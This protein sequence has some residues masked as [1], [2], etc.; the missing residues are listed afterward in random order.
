MWGRASG[1]LC[2]ATARVHS[3]EGPKESRPVRFKNCT[4][5]RSRSAHVA[6][7]LLQEGAIRQLL[8]VEVDREWRRDEMRRRGDSAL[9]CTSLRHEAARR[10]AR[11]GAADGLRLK[12]ARRL[13]ARGDKAIAQGDYD[14]A[15]GLYEQSAQARPRRAMLS[16]TWGRTLQSGSLSRGGAAL[17]RGDRHQA[18]ICQRPRQSRE[19][20]L[21]AGFPRQPNHCCDGS[22]R[23]TRSIRERARCSASCFYVGSRA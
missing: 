20:L 7:E 23:L 13:L 16:T 17:P 12:P 19:A 1:P 21:Q 18:G 5:G 14:R 3:G 15:V 10:A 6:T 11:L 2:V 9:V 4:S 8:Q 22:S